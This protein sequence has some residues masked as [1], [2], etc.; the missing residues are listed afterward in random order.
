LPWFFVELGAAMIVAST[1]VP[2]ASADPF[3]LMLEITMRSSDRSCV[4]FVRSSIAAPY[5]G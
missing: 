5:M 4:Y 3:S 1:I 2:A